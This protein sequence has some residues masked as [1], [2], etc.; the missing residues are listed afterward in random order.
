MQ[1][2]EKIGYYSAITGNIAKTISALV[3]INQ[4]SSP[5]EARPIYGTLV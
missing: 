5:R 4:D 3:I 1:T 2:Q